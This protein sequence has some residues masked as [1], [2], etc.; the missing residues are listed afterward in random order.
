MLFLCERINYG[1][2]IVSIKINNLHD[3][4]FI[5]RKVRK[6]QSLD[7]S[8]LGLLSGNGITFVSNF[9]NGKE[10]VEIGRV[11]KLLEMLGIDIYL[12]LPPSI[13]QQEQAVLQDDVNNLADYSK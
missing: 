3:L 8:T 13:S 5:A 10:T 6:K 2:N 4:S 7:Q 11:F 1:V 12:D 9:E